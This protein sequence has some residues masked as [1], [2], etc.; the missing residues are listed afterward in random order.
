MNIEQRFL[1]KAMEDKNFV[2]FI[3]DRKNFK[4]VMIL[5]FENG[6]LYTDNGSFEIDKICKV[7]ILK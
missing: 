2:S 1:I 6:F 5:E 7:V 3:Y 4:N